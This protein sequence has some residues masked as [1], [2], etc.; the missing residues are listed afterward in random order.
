MAEKTTIEAKQTART[1]STVI[2]GPAEG[3]NPESRT[4]FCVLCLDSGSP[5]SRRPE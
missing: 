4:N 3:R 1:A 2:P 5:L